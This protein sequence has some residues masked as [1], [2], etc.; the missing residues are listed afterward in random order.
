M[1]G[2]YDKLGAPNRAAAVHTARRLGVLADHR[3]DAAF[4]KRTAGV[5]S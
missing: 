3:V 2:L 5:R 1:L 4:P